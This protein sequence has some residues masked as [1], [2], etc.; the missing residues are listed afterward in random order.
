MNCEI[1]FPAPLGQNISDLR[2]A[3]LGDG[4]LDQGLKHIL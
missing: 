4:E 2:S 3:S 1:F